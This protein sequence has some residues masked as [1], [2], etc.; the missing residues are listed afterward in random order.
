VKQLLDVFYEAV[1]LEDQWLRLS[2]GSAFA[3]LI[4]SNLVAYF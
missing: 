1:A 2:G 3:V 4:L